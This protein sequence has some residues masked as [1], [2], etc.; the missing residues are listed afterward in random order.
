MSINNGAQMGAVKETGVLPT[1]CEDEAAFNTAGR[2]VK[3]SSSSLCLWLSFKIQTDS[4]KEL[5]KIAMQNF[6]LLECND[7]KS[8]RSHS[9]IKKLK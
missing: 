3:S 6:I 9:F 8:E 2:V 7:T 5:V 4:F 1:P